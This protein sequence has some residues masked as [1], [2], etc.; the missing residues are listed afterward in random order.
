MPNGFFVLL[1]EPEP[2]SEVVAKDFVIVIDHSGSMSGTKIAMK[3]RM[4]R[5]SWWSN[6][7]AGRCLQRDR[8]R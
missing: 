3:P 2:T 4:P 8:L 6:L 7:N 1:I 5:N